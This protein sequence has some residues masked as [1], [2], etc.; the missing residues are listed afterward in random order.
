MDVVTRAEQ[1]AR[2]AHAGQVDKI[3]EDYIQHVS[4]VALLAKEYGPDAEAAGWLHDVIE[5]TPVTVDDLVAEGISPA[6]IEAVL[7][8]TRPK[9][10]GLIAG[11]TYAEYIDAIWLSGNVIAMAVKVADLRDHLNEHVPPRLK[12]RYERALAI[13]SPALAVL[14]ASARGQLA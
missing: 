14:H 6:V 5:D 11:P 12:P 3:G 4:R 7:L 8:L 2:R 9:T 10:K 13:L 1:I